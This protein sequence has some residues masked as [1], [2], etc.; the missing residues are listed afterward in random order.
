MKGSLRDPVSG[1]LRGASDRIPDE[2]KHAIRR[3]IPSWAW[4]GYMRAS[5]YLPSPIDATPL[6]RIAA[7]DPDRLADPE[8]LARELLPAMGLN[9]T[10]PHLFPEELEPHLG[11]GTHH[12]QLPVQFGPYL[13]EVAKRD[14]RSYL[15][16]GVEHGGTFA[17]TVELLRR[18][19]PV[20]TA[21]AID[22]GPIPRL[23]A[24]YRRRRPEVE[25]VAVDSGSARF[26]ELVRSRGPFDLVL[27]D[28]D[29]SEEGCRRDFEAVRDHAR[30]IAFHDIEEPHYPGVNAVWRSVP[31]DE[32]EL[33]EFTAQYDELLPKVGRRF[34]IGLAIRR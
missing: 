11:R 12:F 34:G 23:L 21:I 19:Q 26:R 14:V 31:Q 8:F 29:H 15:E 18:F 10:S 30:M 6:E 25:F 5:G 28:G 17:I 27:I 7:E 22:L 24:G 9:G 1:P 13:A 20:R 2:T 33:H 16:I 4:Y 3:V 32:F